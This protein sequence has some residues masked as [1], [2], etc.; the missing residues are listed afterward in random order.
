MNL[1]SR[2]PVVIFKRSILMVEVRMPATENKKKGLRMRI[3]II[4]VRIIAVRRET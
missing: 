3:L 1:A 4:H 2:K